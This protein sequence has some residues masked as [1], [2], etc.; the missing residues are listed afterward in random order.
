MWTHGSVNGNSFTEWYTS[1]NGL[2]WTLQGTIVH[3]NA[4]GAESCS[5]AKVFEYDLPSM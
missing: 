3:K 2:N 4:I 1:T 5:Y